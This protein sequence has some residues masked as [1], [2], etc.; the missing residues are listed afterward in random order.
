MI[1]QWISVA[2]DFG[3]WAALAGGA[4]ALAIALWV[5][6]WARL[7]PTT[8]RFIASFGLVS[9]A[10]FSIGHLHGAYGLNNA[11][12]K[13]RAL[14]SEVSQARER[15]REQSALAQVRL[16]QMQALQSEAAGYQEELA[17]GTTKA[18]VSDGAYDRRLQRILG[19][20]ATK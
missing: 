4:G 10:A 8:L 14:Q 6:P 15:A 9:L 17:N 11:Q 20:P 12:A 7:M 2:I 13:L 3:I 19:D 18:C 1:F 5:S 16:L